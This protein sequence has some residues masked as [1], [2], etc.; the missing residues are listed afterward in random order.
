MILLFIGF[1]SLHKPP[2]FEL[3]QMARMKPIF[4]QVSFEYTTFR[5]GLVIIGKDGWVSGC[6]IPINFIHILF[7]QRIRVWIGR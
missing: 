1:V 2:I 7:Q 4:H 5:N 3:F 6:F